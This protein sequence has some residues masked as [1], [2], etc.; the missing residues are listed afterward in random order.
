MLLSKAE[1][2]QYSRQLILKGFGAEKQ[3]ALKAARVLVIGAGGLGCPALLYLAAAGVGTLGIIDGDVVEISN[4]HRQVL[5]THDDIGENK[6]ECAAKRLQA[7]NPFIDVTVYKEALDNSNALEIIT[8]Y[9]LVI[10]GTD[11]FHT[12]YLINDA[13]VILSRPFVYGAIAQFEG[14]VSVFNY[15]NGP[16]Y[17]C[18]F[19]EPPLPGTVASCSEA[20]VIGVF[21]GLIGTYQA[22]EAIK[23][24]TGLGKVR[25]GSLL[26]INTLENTQYTLKISL[27]AAN[28]NIIELSDYEWFCGVGQVP[29]MSVDE[30][31]KKQLKDQFTLLDVREPHEVEAYNIGGL[32]IPLSELTDH[33]DRIPDQEIVVVCQSGIRSARAVN[34]LKQK[35]FTAVYSL[36]GG[37][38]AWKNS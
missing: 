17:R 20:G 18:L 25:A 21:P 7:N 35:G 13:C 5:Y 38:N 26:V 28:K 2:N 8:H 19:P 10:D 29:E 3:E 37:L 12:R 14:Q 32:F 9:D 34:I 15:K 16:T 36:A 24:I 6:A 33:Y 27:N 1:E 30:V 4:L 11:N 31:K 23:M 22:M